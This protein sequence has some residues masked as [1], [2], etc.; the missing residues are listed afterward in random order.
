[1]I[2]SYILEFKY[3]ENNVKLKTGLIARQANSSVIV[4][5]DDTVVLATVVVSK[6]VNNNYN[7][8]PLS[9]NYQ[10]RSYAA[11]KI[12]GSFFRRE[13]RPNEREI[14]IS[15]LID[16]SIRPLFPKN[17]NNEIQINVIVMSLNPQIN[18]DIV[19][20]IAVSTALSLSDIPFLGP[21]G[22]SRIGYI[23][24]N[25]IL[26]P[27]IKQLKNSNLNLIIASTYESIIMIES[28]S[29]LINEKILLNAISFGHKKQQIVIK[30]INKFIK[31]KK[32]KKK[33]YKNN[34]INDFL[35]NEVSN[36]SKNSLIEIYN[37]KNKNER[38]LKLNKNKEEVINKIILNNESIKKNDIENIYIDLE[39]KILRDK[40]INTNKRIDG[41]KIDEIRNIDI[42][43]NY[44]PRTHGSALFTRGDTQSLVTVTL[45][46]TKDAQNLDELICEKTNNFIF[47]YNFPA[48]SVGEIGLLS[49]P[50]R[51][52]I[53][54]GQLAKKSLLPTMPTYKKFPYIIR[55]VSEITESNGSSSMASVCGASLA[56]MDAGVPINFHIAGIAMGLIKNNKDFIILTDIIGEEDNLGD[57]DFKVSGSYDGISSLQIDTKSQGINEKIIELT[58]KQAKIARLHILNKM[59]KIINIPKK[60]ISKFAPK[61][62]IIKINKNKIK[63][64]IGKGGNIIRNLT[65]ETDTIIEIEN[66]GIIKISSNDIK[67]I[68]L[69]IQKINIIT[70]DI[71]IGNIYKGKVTRILD[72]GAFLI[73]NNYK[74]GLLHIS[75]ISNKKVNRITDYLKIGQ[76]INVKVIEI[77]KQGK[78]R[79]SIK[80][81]LKK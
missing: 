5:I 9:I 6:E 12:P 51:R 7:F 8:L 26:N 53:G 48:F 61:I 75:Q 13:G 54:H 19:S 32:I 3:G 45:G 24:N 44:L 41:R 62:N 70:K 52:E 30:N 71:E 65:E 16:R 81:I 43:I 14:L 18:P 35:I 57:M 68:N 11:G 66:D 15:R 78:I 4:D 80:D 72:F 36:L 74:E 46:T 40:I 42:H 22:V 50:K 39:K 59:K 73:I 64:L 63:D 49:I 23:N 55:I 37:I 77:D 20:I 21:I 25:F 28:E 60:E 34:K 10:E 47:H 1:M 79:L 69:A 67:K 58:L 33:K 2:K 76:E 17:F 31:R 56:L 29:N 38:I 27:T